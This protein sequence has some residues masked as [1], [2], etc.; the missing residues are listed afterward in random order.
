MP[1]S[2]GENMKNRNMASFLIVPSLIENALNFPGDLSIV[3]AE[4]DFAY[5]RIRLYVE[6]PE[7][8]SVKP[9]DHIQSI[10]PLVTVKE[11]RDGKLVHTWDFR[12]RE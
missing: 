4:W 3:G 1:R 6:G 9:G 8:P 10:M 5:G 12:F 7:M 2:A 11:G